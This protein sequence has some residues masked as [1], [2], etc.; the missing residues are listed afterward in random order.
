MRLAANTKTAA[1]GAATIIAGMAPG[2]L[3]TGAVLGAAPY[4]LGRGAG[5]AAGSAA[6]EYGRSLDRLDD[7]SMIGLTRRL[8]Q[9][10]HMNREIE[11]DLTAKSL[12]ATRSVAER[13]KVPS[14]PKG[15]AEF[16]D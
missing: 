1:Q 10:L 14:R 8:I 16:A 3:T 13:K 9:V 5:A 7:P 11:G 12:P 2:A 15:P 6:H 4:F